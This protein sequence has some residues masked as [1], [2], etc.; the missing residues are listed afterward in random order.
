MEETHGADPSAVKLATVSSGAPNLSGSVSEDGGELRNRT[1][2]SDPT[3]VFKTSCQPFSGTL[4]GG[5]TQNRTAVPSG[6]W[7]TAS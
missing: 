1:P 2:G 6:Y 4:H 3:L 5:S 7:F